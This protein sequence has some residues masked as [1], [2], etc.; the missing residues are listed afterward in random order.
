MIMIIEKFGINIV[1]ITAFMAKFHWR[2]GKLKKMAFNIGHQL[3][4]TNV[5]KN[6]QKLLNV[7]RTYFTENLRKIKT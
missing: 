7:I 4:Y 2:I 3:L 5:K 1:L 6:V